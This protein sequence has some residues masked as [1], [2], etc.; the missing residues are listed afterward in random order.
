MLDLL[1]AGALERHDLHRSFGS[2]ERLAR[3]G[4]NAIVVC[5]QSSGHTIEN[6]L[7]GIQLWCEK[8]WVIICKN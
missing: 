6:A 5:A 4:G 8:K 2:Q 1:D 3:V 7:L